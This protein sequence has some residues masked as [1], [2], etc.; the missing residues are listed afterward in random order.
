MLLQALLIT[1]L[2]ADNFRMERNFVYIL[3]IDT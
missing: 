2:Q 1:T 3:Q